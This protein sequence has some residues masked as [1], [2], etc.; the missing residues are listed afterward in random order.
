MATNIPPHNLGELV[1]A[2]NYLIDHYARIED[3]SV[4][5]LLKFIPGPDF[6]TGGLIMGTDGIRQAYATGHGRLVVRGMAHI[7]EQGRERH[8]IVITEIPYQLNKTNLLERIAELAREERIE[9]ISDLRDESDRRGMSIIIELSGAQ[10]KKV[11][12]Q[13]YTFVSSRAALALV[14]NIAGTY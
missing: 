3:V 9:D 10:P 8:R 13:L 4:E 11:L 1:A 6:P 2:L 5:E 7:E 12:N 14:E